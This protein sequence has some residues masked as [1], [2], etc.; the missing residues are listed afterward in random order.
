M[1]NDYLRRPR[2]DWDKT[3]VPAMETGHYLLR[4]SQTSR[5]RTWTRVEDALDWLS[6]MSDRHPHD[7]AL[8]YLDTASGWSTPAMA[9]SRELTPCG[10]TPPASAPTASSCSP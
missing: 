7:P 1:K 3:T 6:A 8:N 2:E 10:T 5:E 4:R 9:C